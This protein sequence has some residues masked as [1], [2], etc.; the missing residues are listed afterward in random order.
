MPIFTTATLCFEEVARSGSIRRAA[1][2]LNLSA[3]AVNRQILR[4]EESFGLALFERRPRG[5]RLTAAGEI[6]AA[7]L[8]RQHRE[9]HGVFAQIDALKGLQRGHVVIACLQYLAQVHLSRFIGEFRREHP[10]ITFTILAGSS[11]EVET[12]V[13]DETA[14]LGLCYEPRGGLAL[15]KACAV[16]SRLGVATSRDHPLAAAGTVRL[17]DCL[18]YPIVLPVQGMDSRTF[19]E[20]L[21]LSR[22][23]D[24]LVATESNSFPAFIEL[25]KN[26]TGI[27]FLT[28]IDAVLEVTGGRMRFMTLAEPGVPTPLV[29]TVI[30]QRRTLPFA[31]AL[32]LERL[33]AEL[34][35]LADDAQ[36]LLSPA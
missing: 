24:F 33:G 19:A 12:H 26:G 11:R 28:N 27:G 34:H 36:K 5:M 2:R 23:A 3:S 32:V 21:N 16:R 17:Q 18:G 1:E 35:R 22:F 10:G 9:L 7:S 31:T 13:L 29:C 6:L 4:L 14:D 20:Q 30:K 8:K 15:S 25:I